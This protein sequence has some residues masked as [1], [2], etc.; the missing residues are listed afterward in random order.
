M[1]EAPGLYRRLTVTAII[2][3]AGLGRFSLRPNQQLPNDAFVAAETLQ[4]AL[5]QPRKVNAI[6]LID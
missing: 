5:E 4:D 2:P 3:A 6:A 1:P